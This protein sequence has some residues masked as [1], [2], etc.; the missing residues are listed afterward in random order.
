MKKSMMNNV[1]G[2]ETSIVIG[3]SHA[4]PFNN[5]E[6][7]D[8][9]G[10]MIAYFR[11]N[12]IIQMGDF[13]S[14]DSLSDHD[15]DRLYL[16]EGRRLYDDIMA[17]MDAYNRMMAPTRRYNEARAANKKSQ[18]NPRKIWLRGNHEERAIRY[19]QQRPELV[20]FIPDGSMV[21]AEADGW[22]IVPY[23]K[24][25]Y[26]NGIAFTHIPMNPSINQ[27]VRG[28]YIAATVAQGQQQTCVYGH[29][30]KRS[31]YS[32][33]RNSPSGGERVEG[34]G[35]GCFIDYIPD[36]VKG[37]EEQLSWWSGIVLLT[38]GK[39]L[40]ISYFGMENIKEWFLNASK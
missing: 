11:P 15:E 13:L 36:Y 12:N 3:D 19:M 38:H 7:Y 1:G 17:G 6:R 4:D 24:Y 31:L 2:F 37:N 23:K 14:L 30:H 20:G 27:P 35:A 26:V 5:N 25:A 16:R 34:I 22:E 18:Y 8:A 28:K 39:S 29:D 40:D 32:I 21:G 9:L 10:N 33:H